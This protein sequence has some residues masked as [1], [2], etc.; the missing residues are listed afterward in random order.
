[1]IADGA[2]ELNALLPGESRALN[3][4]KKGGARSR[5]IVEEFRKRKSGV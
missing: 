5:G 1:M 2:R 4:A 3:E